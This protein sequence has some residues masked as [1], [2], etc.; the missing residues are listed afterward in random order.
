VFPIGACLERERLL[1]RAMEL[2][3]LHIQTVEEFSKQNAK[4]NST[5]EEAALLRD[6]MKSSFVI[7]QLAWEQYGDLVKKHGC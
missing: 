5:Q 7:A 6:Q 4:P 3:N 2:I 1:R